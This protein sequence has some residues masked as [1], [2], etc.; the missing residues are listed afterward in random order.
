MMKFFPSKFLL[1]PA[2]IC[3]FRHVQNRKAREGDGYF[4]TRTDLGLL[5]PGVR[6]RASY[7]SLKGILMIGDK[8]RIVNE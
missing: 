7:M 2:T 8:G 6:K 5:N 3:L 4:S 1:P